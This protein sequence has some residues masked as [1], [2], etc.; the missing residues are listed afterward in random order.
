VA[1]QEGRQITHFTTAVFDMVNLG[2]DPHSEA[3]KTDAI[4]YFRPYKTVLVRT[5]ADGGESYYVQGVHRATIT[6]LHR[7][8]MQK[9][10]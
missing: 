5:V 9:N 1:H 10:A 3:P 6:N 2:E 8:I 7:L 4:Y